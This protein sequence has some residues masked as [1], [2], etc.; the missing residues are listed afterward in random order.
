MGGHLSISDFGNPEEE[1]ARFE[2][3]LLSFKFGAIENF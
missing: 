2:N 3:V 1:H